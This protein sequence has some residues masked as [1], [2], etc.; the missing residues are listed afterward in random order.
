MAEVDG[1]RAYLK[2]ASRYQRLLILNT[3][4]PAHPY[5]IDLF[6]VTGGQDA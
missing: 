3:V 1:G 4:D 5:V 2:K 6:A